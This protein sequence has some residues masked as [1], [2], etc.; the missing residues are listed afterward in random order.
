MRHVALVVKSRP[1]PAAHPGTS[2][3]PV[4]LADSPTHG[5][6][7]GH[8]PHRLWPGLLSHSRS[9]A[10]PPW[11]LPLPPFR[12]SVSPAAPSRI[13]TPCCR[14]AVHSRTQP[15]AR[16]RRRRRRHLARTSRRRGSASGREWREPSPPLPHAGRPLPLA[17]GA[18]SAAVVDSR[19]MLFACGQPR[20]AMRRPLVPSGCCVK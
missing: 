19:W 18:P 20:P 9:P 7:P 17:P 2:L 10:L 13:K 8:C 16:L 15:P 6:G 14:A 11:L 3:P 1:G 12:L 5:P 4:P